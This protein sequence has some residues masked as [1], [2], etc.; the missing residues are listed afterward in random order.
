MDGV[1]MQP[2]FKEV[3]LKELRDYVL[4]HR[5]DEQAFYTYVDRI[6]AECTRVTHPP[7]KSIEDMA[8][9]PDFLEKLRR[10]PG[11]KI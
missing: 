1:S 9:Y 3:S 11:R 6:N 5:E 4:S 2:N 7:L 10:D 8:N